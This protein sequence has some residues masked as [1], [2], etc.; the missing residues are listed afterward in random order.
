MVSKVSISTTSDEATFLPH[1]FA[2]L[3]KTAGSVI[4]YELLFIMQLDK[5]RS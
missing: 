2:F 5:D 3:A 4:K 1:Y